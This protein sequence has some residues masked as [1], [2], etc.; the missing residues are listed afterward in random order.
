MSRLLWFMPDELL[1]VVVILAAIGLIVGV[2]RD[3]VGGLLASIVLLLLIGPF[4]EALFVSLPLWVSLVVLLLMGLALVRWFLEMTLGKEA[5]GHVLGTFVVKGIGGT[6]R[7]ALL[8]L[9]GALWLLGTAVRG[10]LRI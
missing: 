2:R 6:L 8:P 9:R 7:L 4:V 3:R 1:V 5:A 10:L